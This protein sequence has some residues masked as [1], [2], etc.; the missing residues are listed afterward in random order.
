MD[1]FRYIICKGNRCLLIVRPFIRILNKIVQN[2]ILF[3]K[4]GIKD[5]Y[6]TSFKFRP[7]GILKNPLKTV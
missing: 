3:L 5:Y 6:A 4:F 1:N 7:G 2:D